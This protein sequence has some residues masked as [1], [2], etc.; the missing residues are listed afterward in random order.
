MRCPA[1]KPFCTDRVCTAT[2]D[3]TKTA[4]RPEFTCTS[5]GVFPDPSDYSLY[6]VC[7]APNNA[8]VIY[9]CP[10]GYAFDSKAV[11]CSWVDPAL[12]DKS[13]KVDCS[14]PKNANKMVLY[15]GNAAYYAFCFGDGR[16]GK[17]VQ[18]YMY[19]C[20]DEL[21][22]VY[23]LSLGQCVYNCMSAGNFTDR[24]D[25]NGYYSCSA[26]SAGKFVST[27]VV[28]PAKSYFLDGQCVAQSKKK[29]VSELPAPLPWT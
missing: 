7:S 11:T 23:D 24:T 6:R 3:Y 15:E 9:Q 20:Q 14:K 17:E 16:N 4:C 19:K 8:S 5:E 26:G 29:C 13:I 28:C 22:Q 27:K 21:N 10:P 18:V 1:D 12:P 2:A 25:C